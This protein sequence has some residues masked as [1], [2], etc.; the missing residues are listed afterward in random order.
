[1]I[2]ATQNSS[3]SKFPRHGTKD[4]WFRTGFRDLFAF[5]SVCQLYKIPTQGIFH[6][7]PYEKFLGCQIWWHQRPTNSV[8]LMPNI[9]FA[10]CIANNNNLQS[11]S[12]WAKAK[13]WIV[14][15]QMFAFILALVKKRSPKLLKQ[16]IAPHNFKQGT[17]YFECQTFWMN[18]F[19]FNMN[20][21][22]GEYSL[23]NPRHDFLGP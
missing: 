7:T 20:I 9:P 12:C 19:L 11:P 2:W 1:V 10:D 14:P 4:V 18:P 17:H 16:H 23:L 3:V 13:F 15:R 6:K 22:L 5:I 21:L 8:H